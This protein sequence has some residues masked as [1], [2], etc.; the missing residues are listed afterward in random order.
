MDDLIRREDAINAF[1]PKHNCDWYTPW[2]VETLKSLPSIEPRKGRWIGEEEDERC[3]CSKCGY[4]NLYVEVYAFD[5]YKFCP[6][7]GADMRGDKDV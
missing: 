5:G 7:C 4:S 6:N 2:I 1:N 3:F